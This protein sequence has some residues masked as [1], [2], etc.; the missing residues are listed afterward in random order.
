MQVPKLAWA[1]HTVSWLLLFTELKFMQEKSLIFPGLPPAPSAAFPEGL[2]GLLGFCFS[3]WCYDTEPQL[4]PPSV[5]EPHWSELDGCSASLGRTHLSESF[6]PLTTG[7][8]F[9][10]CAACFGFDVE[11]DV[12]LAFLGVQ[13]LFGYFITTLRVL[14]LI[15]FFGKDWGALLQEIIYVI[16]MGTVRRGR[17]D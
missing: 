10:A 4:S 7:W 6:V 5:H 2:P 1:C 15:C 8:N 3:S 16:W 13:F 9:T 14:F 12:H 11:R 17:V